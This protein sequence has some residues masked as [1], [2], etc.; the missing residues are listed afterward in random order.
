MYGCQHGSTLFGDDLTGGAEEE[1]HQSASDL[2][3]E[4]SQVNLGALSIKLSSTVDDIDHSRIY[5]R[6]CALTVESTR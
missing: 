3:L 1:I 4:C 6:L 2:R 5:L